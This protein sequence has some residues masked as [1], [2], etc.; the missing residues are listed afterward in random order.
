MPLA[1]HQIKKTQKET[2]IG[3]IRRRRLQKTCKRKTKNRQSEKDFKQS[4]VLQF[5]D[6]MSKIDSLWAPIFNRI[7]V[8]LTE[9]KMFNC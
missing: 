3:Q 1:K 5:I 2:D 7:K 8:F 4:V 9:N 6:S